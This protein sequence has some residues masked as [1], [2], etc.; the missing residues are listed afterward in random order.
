[1]SFSSSGY[2]PVSTWVATNITAIPT[3]IFTGSVVI[4][5]L[6]L[7]NRKNFRPM[8][9]RLWDDIS[10]I[11]GTNTSDKIQIRVDAKEW[12]TVLLNAQTG[13]S[14]STGLSINATQE[15][16]DGKLTPSVTSSFQ[17]FDAFLYTN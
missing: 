9:F 3:L 17:Q 1:M 4:F 6:E 8:F 12:K 14:F 7:D 5:A 13:V 16:S 2:H 11:I 10:V 15:N